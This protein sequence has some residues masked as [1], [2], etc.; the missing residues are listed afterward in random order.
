MTANTNQGKSD[1]APPLATPALPLAVVGLQVAALVFMA[2]VAASNHT[3]A[4]RRPWEPLLTTS[5]A[6]AMAQCSLGA[7]WWA[8]SDWPMYL[9]TVVV[10]VACAVFWGMLLAVLDETRGQPDRAAGW[11]GGLATQFVLTALLTAA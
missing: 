5:V 2:L 6:L 11:A 10:A 9:K 7:I 4:A 3:L 8:R 1:Q